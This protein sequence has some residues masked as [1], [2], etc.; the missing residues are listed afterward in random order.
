MS[1]QSFC[2]LCRCRLL[3]LCTERHLIMRCVQ[4]AKCQQM[5]TCFMTPDPWHLCSRVFASCCVQSKFDWAATG[6]DTER[7]LI[8]YGPCQFPTLGLIVQRA[9]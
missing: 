3:A 8:S 2:I 4:P 6:L 7:P 5:Q 1:M 9:W